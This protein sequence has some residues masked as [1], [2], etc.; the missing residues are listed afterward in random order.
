MRLTCSE[1][2]AALPTH[3]R[4]PGR[5]SLR[6]SVERAEMSDRAPTVWFQNASLR[7]EAT[8]GPRASHPSGQLPGVTRIP[9]VLLHS[10]FTE[11]LPSVVRGIAILVIDFIW[12]FSRLEHPD[13]AV[14]RERNRVHRKMDMAIFVRPPD[15]STGP[16]SVPLPMLLTGFEML[17]R[18]YFPP[19][20][21]T[22]R[23]VVEAFSQILSRRQNFS[24][25]LQSFE[26]GA[27]S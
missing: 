9:S 13:D 14:C 17:T 5:M 18:P 12:P 15:V 23:I 3:E 2:L 27:V 19:K 20:A 6:R 8:S 7:P 10:R 24:R 4:A 25:H 16:T 22:V 11:V 26:A 1:E 21:A